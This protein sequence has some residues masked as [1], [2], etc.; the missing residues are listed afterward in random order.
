MLVMKK[1]LVVLLILAVSTGVFAQGNWSLGFEAEYTTRLDFEPEEAA[2]VGGT[3]Y[4]DPYNW[5]DVVQGIVSIGYS[6]GGFTGGVAL[7]QKDGIDSFA[8]FQG[9]AYFFRAESNLHQLLNGGGALK[10]DGKG[11][12]RLWGWYEMIDGM[13]HL[14]AAYHAFEAAWWGSDL[15]GA[16]GGSPIDHFLG[17]NG[18]D[19]HFNFGDGG[20]FTYFDKWNEDVYTS[21]YLMGELNISGLQFGLVL[22]GIFY[23]PNAGSIVNYLVQGPD[24]DDPDDRGVLK[25]MIFGAK[26]DIEPFEFAAQLTMEDY[27]IYFGGKFFA[28]PITAGLSFMGLLSSDDEKRMKVGVS[29]NYDADAFGVGLK[30]KLENFTMDVTANNGYSLI[31]VEPSFF[32]NAIPSHLQFQLL[33]GFYFATPFFDNNDDPMETYWGVQPALFWNFMGTGA[34]GYMWGGTGM[35]FRYRIFQMESDNFLGGAFNTNALDLC[36]K[37]SM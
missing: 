8:A 23:D 19:G 33:A 10:N 22:P 4:W 21:N 5:D 20:V 36:F 11:N 18:G 6:L 13:I 17:I 31:S 26:L 1:I 28:G 14:E 35:I 7:K 3:F 24:A 12:G 27:G 37:F 30:G 9:D 34:G 2:T 29:F 32:Y 16:F 25:R 15:T